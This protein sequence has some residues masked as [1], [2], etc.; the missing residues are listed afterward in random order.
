MIKIDKL[1]E[2]FKKATKAQKRVMI[3][4]DVL[5]QIKAERYFPKRGEWA[6]PLWSDD[7]KSIDIKLDPN[8]SIK[9]AFKS[10][11]INSCKVCALGGLFMSCTNLNNNTTVG[12]MKTEYYIGEFVND[13]VK[14][15][16]GLNRIF[17]QKQLMLIETYFEGGEGY[18]KSYSH[19]FSYS[20]EKLLVIF[21]KSFDDDERLKMIMQNIIDNNGTFKPKKLNI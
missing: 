20:D 13:D 14:I 4:K 9:D 21:F 19:H 5:A 18:F 15:S 1:N 16:N 10:K 2:E 7:Q 6:R 8:S 11:A 17:T 12:D 3:A